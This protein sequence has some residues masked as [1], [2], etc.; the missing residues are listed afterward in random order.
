M[1]RLDKMACVDTVEDR[2]VIALEELAHVAPHTFSRGGIDVEIISIGKEKRN[3]DLLSVIVRCR[4]NGEELPI[5]NPLYYH[6]APMMVLDGTVDENG[7]QNFV[8]D[9]TEAMRQ[10]VFET[11]AVTVPGIR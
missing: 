11:L 8:E 3:G 7:Q 4:V 6:N 9:S 2:R 1:L 5:D 10:I